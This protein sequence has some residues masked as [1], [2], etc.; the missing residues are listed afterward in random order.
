MIY[1]L[2]V[3]YCY[4]TI[5]DHVCVNSQLHDYKGKFQDMGYASRQKYMLKAEEMADRYVFRFGLIILVFFCR[6]QELPRNFSAD[7]LRTGGKYADYKPLILIV[8][9]E[10]YSANLLVFTVM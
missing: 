3:C 7:S 9:A 8:D 4:V 6:N 10:C 1:L 5:I 2:L